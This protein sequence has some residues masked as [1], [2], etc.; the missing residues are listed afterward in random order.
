MTEK[1][2]KFADEYIIDCNATRAYKAAYPN[3]KKDNVA[4]AAGARLLRIVKVAAYIEE[5]LAE[6]SSQKT[7]NAQEVME[8]LTSVMRGESESSVVVVEGYGEGCSEAK[9]IE[10]P[11]DEKERLKAAELLGRH[12]AIFTDKVKAEG[13]IP[14]VISGG[15]DLED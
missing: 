11:P 9:I 14:V 15:E 7:A 2:Q 10:K 1:Q 13:A 4:A 8:Y 5:K 6:I 3:V 12:Y